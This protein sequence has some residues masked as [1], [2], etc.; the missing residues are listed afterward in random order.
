MIHVEKMTEENK[1]VMS[2]V[3]QGLLTEIDELDKDNIMT[4]ALTQPV[5]TLCLLYLDTWEGKSD[6][7][8]TLRVMCKLPLRP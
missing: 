3:L 8:L 5:S 1:T 4:R 7:Q 2:N 6:G